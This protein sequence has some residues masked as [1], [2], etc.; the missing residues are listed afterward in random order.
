[1][2][3]LH[4]MRVFVRVV[5]AGGFSAAARQLDTS[6]AR[7]SRAIADL[8][9]RLGMRLLNRT[10]RRS[11]LTEAGERYFRRCEQILGCIAQMEAEVNGAHAWPSGTLRLHCMPVLGQRN[12]LECLSRYR[13][14]FPDVDV[15]LTF[16]QRRPDLI[17]EGFDVSIVLG[18]SLPDSGLVSQRLGATFSIMCAS[19]RYIDEH[20]VPVVPQDLARHACLGLV[21]PHMPCDEWALTGPDGEEPAVPVLPVFRVN[22]ADALAAGIRDGMGVG[23]LPRPAAMSGLRNGDFVRVMPHHHAHD[24]NIYAVHSSRRS[25]DPK[26]RTWI[27]FLSR[28]V[29]PMLESNEQAL[30]RFAELTPN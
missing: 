7:I 13:Q 20:G 17:D 11:T 25:L 3:T 28:E 26:V 18:R 14:R 4:N 16:S 24:M 27:D 8:E 12:V 21:S 6:T 29:P 2:D 23:L 22:D 5:D 1:M 19:R 10:T 9:G 15:D 30:T